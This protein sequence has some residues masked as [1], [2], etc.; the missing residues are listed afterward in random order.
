[1]ATPGGAARLDG[2]TV[3]GMAPYYRRRLASGSV[4][5][6][7]RDHARRTRILLTMKPG[8]AR[9]FIP[10]KSYTITTERS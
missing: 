2:M 3:N 4:R 7:F 5:V 9:E 8:L 1:M 10:G 6:Y